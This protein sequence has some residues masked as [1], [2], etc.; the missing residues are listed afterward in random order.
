MGERAI[1]VAVIFLALCTV[2]IVVSEH[3]GIDHRDSV[4]I[5]FERTVQGLGTGP[6]GVLTGCGQSFDFRCC[7]HCDREFYPVAGGGQFC[8]NHNGLLSAPSLQ[9][10]VP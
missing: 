5:S 4:V 8:G 10:Q 7:E 6:S 1:V 9:K 3:G 2:S